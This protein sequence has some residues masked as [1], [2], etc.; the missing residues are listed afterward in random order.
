MRIWNRVSL[1]RT[2]SS[3]TAGTKMSGRPTIV[4]APSVKTEVSV[5][6]YLPKKTGLPIIPLL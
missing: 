3:L 5:K 1:F 6:L 2:L 4:L